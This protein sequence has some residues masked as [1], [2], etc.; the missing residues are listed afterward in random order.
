MIAK[1]KDSE[2]IIEGFEILINDRVSPIRNIY[3]DRLRNE[4]LIR[5]IEGEFSI[6]QMINVIRIL[7]VCR[8]PLYRETIDL[9]W[10]GFKVFFLRDMLIEFQ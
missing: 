4:I 8:D 1:S 9:L 7:S 6:M 3:R 5:A 2:V 10:V